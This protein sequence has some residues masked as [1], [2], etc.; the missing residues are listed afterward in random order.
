MTENN[1]ASV[2]HVYP[3]MPFNLGDRDEAGN[4]IPE[5]AQQSISDE[6]EGDV[7]YELRDLTFEDRPGCIFVATH[8]VEADSEDDFRRKFAKQD[9]VAGRLRFPP[10]FKSL[11]ELTKDGKT[12]TK[13]ELI[14]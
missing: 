8:E 13:E 9:T 1:K 6:R 5:P 12:R 3:K 11:M 14:Q 4:F 10:H 7:W 2:T